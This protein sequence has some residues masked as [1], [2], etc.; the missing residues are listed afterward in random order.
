MDMFDCVLPTRNARNGVLFTR[1]G[2][3]NILNARFS[4]DH[5]PVDVDC[6]CST[7][8]GF[9]RAYLRHLFKAREL[10]GYQLATV[11]NLALYHWLL[12]EARLAI[13]D[14]RFRPWK[15]AITSRMNTDTVMPE[16]YQGRTL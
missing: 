14:D 4:N 11:H 16:T 6:S 2:K 5:T 8:K 7:C 12:R 10:L 13:V 15:A 1:D 3:L 9:S